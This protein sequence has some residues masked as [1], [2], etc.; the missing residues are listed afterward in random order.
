MPNFEYVGGDPIDHFL[1][2]RIEPGD[3]VELGVDLGEDEPAGP[4]KPTKKKPRR[5]SDEAPTST[6]PASD[7]SDT[8]EEG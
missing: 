6:E 7:E 2:G 3:I 8:T 4:W 5:H 1:L